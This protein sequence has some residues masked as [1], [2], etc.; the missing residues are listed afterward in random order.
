MLGELTLWSDPRMSRMKLEIVI[1]LTLA[2]FA[3]AAMPSGLGH[4]GDVIISYWTGIPPVIDGVISEDE[5]INASKTSIQLRENTGWQTP[6]EVFVMNDAENI[7]ICVKVQCEHPRTVDCIIIRFDEWHDGTLTVGDENYAEVCGDG[8]FY[9][10]Y[11]DGCWRSDQHLDLEAA[12]G[13]TGKYWVAEFNI[14]MRSEDEQDL[15]VEP[16]AVIGFH[17]GFWSGSRGGAGWPDPTFSSTNPSGWADLIL[18]ATGASAELAISHMLV[19]PSPVIVNRYFIVSCRIDNIGDLSAY[20]VTAT[21]W[22]PPNI[23]YAPGEGTTHFVGRIE[24]GQSKT[25]VWSLKAVSEGTFRINVTVSGFNTEEVLR[26]VEFTAIDP[27]NS[28]PIAILNVDKSAVDVNETVLFNASNS[29]DPDGKII[30]YFFDFGDGTNSGWITTPTI[31]H[32]YSSPGEYNASLI[33]MDDDGA[34]SLV[35]GQAYILITVVPEF[36]SATM[37][38]LMLTTL[39]ATILLKKRKTKPELIS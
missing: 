39:I 28:P 27:P 29:Y 3:F 36:P 24:P 17:I 16:G 18:S 15:D 13:Y 6:A 38:T 12:I 31:Y 22:T 25:C 11:W 20:D 14:P 4:S 5:W 32:T 19:D 21:I 35:S 1:L 7:Y 34:E 8:D 9:D 10:G 33:V 37:L 2:F 23:T 30:Y 26:T